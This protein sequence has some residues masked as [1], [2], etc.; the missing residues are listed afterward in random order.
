MRLGL[1]ASF[2]FA[3]AACGSAPATPAIDA[4]S[5]VDAPGSDGGCAAFAPNASPPPPPYAG[6]AFLDPGI[7]TSADPTSFVDLTFTGQAPRE[8]FDRRTGAFGT[9]NA[10]LF[11]ARFGASKTVEIQ[12]NPEFSRA[13]AEAE[14]RTYAT[15]VGRLPAFAFRDLDTMWIHAGRFPFGG[16]NRNLL[17]HTAQGEEYTAG[18]YLE[19]IFVHEGTHT[20][21]DGDH[22]AAARW[23]EAQAADGTFVST[24]ARDNP[25]REDV[26]ETMVPYLAQRFRA[27]RLAPGTVDT[28]RA[29]IPNRLRYLDCLGVTMATLP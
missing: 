19:E 17:I 14:A 21:I 12:V 6:T 24:Y 15:V 4:P 9:V 7:I 26:A 3:L 25:T 20:S 27:D 11:L 16:G 1:R 18:G 23:L 2:A 22:G 10:Y 28:I 13:Q 5:S 8:M 29:A